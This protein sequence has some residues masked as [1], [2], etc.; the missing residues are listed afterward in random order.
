MQSIRY[1]LAFLLPAFVWSHAHAQDVWVYQVVQ[2]NNQPRL[3]RAPPVDLTY[4]R[5]GAPM[6]VTDR[7]SS[8]SRGEPLT[9]QQAAARRASPHLIITLVPARVGEQIGRQ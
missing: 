7:I 8:A 9:P 5:D 6:P 4:P 2:G 3:M 1:A